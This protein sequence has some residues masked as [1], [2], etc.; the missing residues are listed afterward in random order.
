MGRPKPRSASE[1]K[2]GP[3]LI[4]PAYVRASSCATSIQ[5]ESEST[6]SKNDNVR[7]TA[8]QQRQRQQPTKDGNNDQNTS[9]HTVATV[10]TT[11]TTKPKTEAAAAASSNSHYYCCSVRKT[12]DLRG[13]VKWSEKK[14]DLEQHRPC[15]HTKQPGCWLGQGVRPKFSEGRFVARNACRQHNCLLHAL[16]L[17]RRRTTIGCLRPTVPTLVR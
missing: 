1:T 3:A 11:T 4:S 13:G 16:F 10:V 8:Q 7:L 14:D 9:K 6:T 5:N 12:R 17:T 2:N 15:I